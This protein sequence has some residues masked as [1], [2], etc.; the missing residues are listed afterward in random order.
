V[1]FTGHPRGAIYGLAHTPARFHEPLLR[2]QT[3]IHNLYLTG[4]DVSTAGVAGALMGGVL[5]ASVILKR[6]VLKQ[7]LRN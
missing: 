4:A 7:A 1:E 5:A 2:P 3:P 6:N